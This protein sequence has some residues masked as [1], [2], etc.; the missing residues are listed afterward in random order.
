MVL[1][2]MVNVQECSYCTVGFLS[3]F[4][5]AAEI[6]LFVLVGAAVDINYAVSAGISAVMLIFAVLLFRMAG[7]AVCLIIGRMSMVMMR[8]RLLSIVRVAITAGTLQPNPMIS[9]MNDLP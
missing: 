2:S 3:G 1:Q 6:V 5:V 7:V 8:E 9:G 4:G